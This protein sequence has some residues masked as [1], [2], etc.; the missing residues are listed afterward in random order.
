MNTPIVPTPNTS[1]LPLRSGSEPM[2]DRLDGI[3]A[4]GSD[5]MHRMAH[6][7]EE[8]AHRSAGQL[9]DQGAVWRDGAC[10]QIRLHPLR[11]VAI[12]AGTGAVL[13]LLARWL[14][15]SR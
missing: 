1:G 15:S 11:S 7:A 12:A 5:A 3:T 8:W 4:Q 14:L 6:T 2:T 9:R 10:A 13:T